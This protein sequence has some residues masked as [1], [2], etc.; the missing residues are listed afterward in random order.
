MRHF[1]AQS[2]TGLSSTTASLG[3]SYH[4]GCQNVKCCK[5]GESRN[6]RIPV[7]KYV[8]E[9]YVS[10]SAGQTSPDVWNRTMSGPTKSTNVLHLNRF[11]NLQNDLFL[12]LKVVA[13]GNGLKK[14]F[15]NRPSTFTVDVKD[16]GKN[17]TVF[18]YDHYRFVCSGVKHSRMNAGFIWCLQY[19]N[20][21]CVSLNFFQFQVTHCCWLVL[22]H[23]QE[24]HWK[25][26]PTRNKE[27]QHTRYR[28][29]QCFNKNW[30][31]IPIQT[32]NDT[33]LPM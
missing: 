3:I 23:L 8:S 16:A 14:A 30:L 15:V 9:K 13:K 6:P 26:F 17:T 22:F 21:S 24:T 2:G 11:I 7:M 1:A 10:D 27:E 20:Y 31:H 28:N 29:C 18:P 19:W 33:M 4:T 25:R 5:R 12:T 32:K